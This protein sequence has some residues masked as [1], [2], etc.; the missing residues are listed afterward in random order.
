MSCG[1]N[2]SALWDFCV[3]QGEGFTS[4]ID[5]AAVGSGRCCRE[6]TVAFKQGVLRMLNG[7]NRSQGNWGKL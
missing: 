1:S 5:R 3:E 4:R 7:S 6:G 2:L